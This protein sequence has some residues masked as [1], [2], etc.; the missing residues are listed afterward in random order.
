MRYWVVMPAAGAG[1]RFG[2]QYPKQHAVLAGS[3]VLETSLRIFIADDR[4]QGVALALAADDPRRPA[5]SRR[6]PSRVRVVT[7]GAQRSESVLL[8]LESLAAVADEGI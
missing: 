8:G 5:L 3:T 1:R 2:G 6:L 7:G 4:C